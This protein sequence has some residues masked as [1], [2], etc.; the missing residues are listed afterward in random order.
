MNSKKV[1]AY[2][3]NHIEGSTLT[4]DQTRYI[5]LIFEITWLLQI[6][7]L[8]YMQNLQKLEALL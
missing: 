4:E 2:N 5:F 1:F 8:R 7:V 3:T 6:I